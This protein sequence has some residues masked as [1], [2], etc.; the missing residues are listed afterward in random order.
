MKRRRYVE[1][2]DRRVVAGPHRGGV[3]EALVDLT[4][5]IGNDNVR[6]VVLLIARKDG[7]LDYQICGEVPRSALALVSGVMMKWATEPS[8]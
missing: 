8:D 2:G 7:D 4:A 3:D 1:R 5:A 6:G